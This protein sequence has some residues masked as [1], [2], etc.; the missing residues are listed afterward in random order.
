MLEVRHQL[1]NLETVLHPGKGNASGLLCNLVPYE[2]ALNHLCKCSS[3]AT[4]TEKI[5]IVSCKMVPD[6]YFMNSKRSSTAHMA[7][8]VFEQAVQIQLV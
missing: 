6:L 3:S 7:S 8:W 5:A 2:V 4:G 1:I